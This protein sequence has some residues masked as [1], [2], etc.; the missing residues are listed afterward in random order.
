MRLV[1]L[2]DKNTLELIMIAFFRLTSPHTDAEDPNMWTA[3]S[4]SVLQLFAIHK[5]SMSEFFHAF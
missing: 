1:C 4:L 2:R 3:A 5:C